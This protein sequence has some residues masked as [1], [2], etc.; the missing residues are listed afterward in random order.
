VRNNAGGFYNHLLFFDNMAAAGSTTIPA[1]LKAAIE[2]K[3][4][5]MEEFKKQ[6]SEAGKTRFGSGWAWLSVDDKGELF[7]SSTANQ[8]N[9]LMDIADKKGTPILALD[10]WEHAYY[11]K[12]QNRR[13]DYIDTFWSVINWKVVA[14]RWKAAK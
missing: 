1:D 10:V 4:S 13:V 8:D 5:S 14:E 11:L 7:I 3:F 12:Y 6:F 9:P 2:K